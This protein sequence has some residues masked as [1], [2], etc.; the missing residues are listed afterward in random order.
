MLLGYS[1]AISCRHWLLAEVTDTIPSASC[2]Y[3]RV[4]PLDLWPFIN[5]RWKFKGS[6][7]EAG[8]LKR[9]PAATFHP[10][11]PGAMLWHSSKARSGKK[12]VIYFVNESL[13]FSSQIQDIKQIPCPK[14][15]L[16]TTKFWG[17]GGIEF[18]LSH[19]IYAF[20]FPCVL[21]KCVEMLL[22]NSWVI[23][24]Y[25]GVQ[26]HLKPPNRA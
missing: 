2:N 13:W 4:F 5:L 22:Q 18:T 19:S 23:W 21:L 15:W 17:I 24:T 7:S 25:K 10:A 20:C 1:T 9:P 14:N 3:V 11:L 6:T 8:F 16:L 12:P 26:T